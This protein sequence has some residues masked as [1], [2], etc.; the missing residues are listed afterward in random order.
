M[1]VND[2]AILLIGVTFY[3]FKHVQIEKKTGI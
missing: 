3:L 1:K 2:F